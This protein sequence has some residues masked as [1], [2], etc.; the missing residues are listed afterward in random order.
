MERDIGLLDIPAITF[1]RPSLLLGERKERRPMEKAAMS[2][3]KT[4][5]GLF[6]GP[7]KK[8]KAIGVEKVA[9]AMIRAAKYQRVGNEV[10][11]NFEV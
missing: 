10:V 6:V 11:S 9:A 8:Y 3:A 5:S 2:V 4:L 1:F 7:L